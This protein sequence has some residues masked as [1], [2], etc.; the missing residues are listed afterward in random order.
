MIDIHCH[1]LPGL[2]DG[3]KS[4][5]TTLAM[6]RL[7]IADGIEHI[8]VTP[9]ANDTYGYNRDRVRELV[10]ELDAKI[11]SQ[12]AFSLGSEFHLS[13]DNIEDALQHPQRYTIAAKQ[14]LLVELSDYAVP[15][16]VDDGLFRLQ[17]SGIIPIITHPERNPMLQS[18]PERVLAWVQAGCLI[19]VTASALTRVCGGTTPKIRDV[20]SESGRGA[21]PGHGRARRSAS[22]AD[23]FQ[24][25]RL[26][27]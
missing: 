23:S 18:Q 25:A 13:Y 24:S 20:S 19:Q 5:E 26:G 17:A 22:Q 11:N 12:L 8:V 10:A 7:A 16:Q 6:C 2:D 15:P 3:P 27:G 21:H 9:H 4:W 14:Y 1:L